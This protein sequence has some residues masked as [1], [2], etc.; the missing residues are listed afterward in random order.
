M[1]DVLGGKR[2]VR[3][4]P[5]EAMMVSLW[6]NSSASTLFLEMP[7]DGLSDGESVTRP[8][9]IYSPVQCTTQAIS[10]IPKTLPNPSST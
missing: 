3:M 6:R 4:E 2:E 10:Q 1:R 8:R 7:I 9:I 5:I